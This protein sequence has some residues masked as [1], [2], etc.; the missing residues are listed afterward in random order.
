MFVRYCEG[1][2]GHDDA[3][4]GHPAQGGV[5]PLHLRPAHLLRPRGGGGGTDH[6]RPA[7][8][9]GRPEHGR[10]SQLLYTSEFHPVSAVRF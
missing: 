7:P 10:V 5:L 2:E 3:R 4:H 6:P 8:V 9:Q 1:G